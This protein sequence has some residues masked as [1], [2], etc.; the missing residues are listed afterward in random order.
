MKGISRP[1]FF[2]EISTL[3]LKIILKKGCQIY[4]AHMQEIMN[5]KEPNLEY[6]PVL[7]EF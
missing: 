4:V 5:D 1:I 6:Y 2:R 3:Q 7:K